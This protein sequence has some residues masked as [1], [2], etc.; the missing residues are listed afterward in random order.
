MNTTCI[1]YILANEWLTIYVGMTDDLLRRLKQH[2][3]K[4]SDFTSRYE[5]DRLVWFEVHPSRESAQLRER[6]IKGW[7]RNRI[8]ALIEQTNPEWRDLSRGGFAEWL[9][10]EK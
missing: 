1:V 7:R 8:L 10:L 3:E 4:R 6:Q 5:I 2:R 9:K